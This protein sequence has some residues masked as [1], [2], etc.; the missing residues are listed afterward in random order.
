MAEQGG[1]S[2]GTLLEGRDFGVR[3]KREISIYN[4]SGSFPQTSGQERVISGMRRLK[5]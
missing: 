1:N 2:V 4:E 3:P 5:N